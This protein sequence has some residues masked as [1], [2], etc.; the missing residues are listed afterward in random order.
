MNVLVEDKLFVLCL[1]FVHFIKGYT[2]IIQDCGK[3]NVTVVES[4]L[5]RVLFLLILWDLMKLPSQSHYLPTSVYKNYFHWC[6]YHMKIVSIVCMYSIFCLRY[7][8]TLL[9]P[10]MNC[11]T[12]GILYSKITQ[13]YEHYIILRNLINFTSPLSYTPWVGI[14]LLV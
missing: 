11:V 2:E 9:V 12:K 7:K 5:C 14:N 1:L 13:T 8:I 6:F 10:I 4:T 3:V